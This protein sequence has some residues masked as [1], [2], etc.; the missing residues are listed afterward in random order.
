MGGPTI[1][2]SRPSIGDVQ[3]NR[4]ADKVIRCDHAGVPFDFHTGSPPI[5]D[6][7]IP[8]AAIPAITGP[9][10]PSPYAGECL[11]GRPPRPSHHPGPPAFPHG[12]SRQARNSLAVNRR[13]IRS[14]PVG[15]PPPATIR[16]AMRPGRRG[17]GVDPLGATRLQRPR[18]LILTAAMRMQSR[19]G[20]GWR[21]GPNANSSGPHW[22]RRRHAEDPLS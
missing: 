4:L 11:D 9:E 8:R 12:T 21:A 5:A 22:P 14:T 16:S 10:R 13:I 6:T 1:L 2:P 20:G 17:V 18:R 15:P 19:A 3:P 7:T